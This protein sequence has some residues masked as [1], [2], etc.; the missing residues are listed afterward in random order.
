[1]RH[2]CAE[3]WLFLARQPIREPAAQAQPASHQPTHGFRRPREAKRLDQ[4]VIQRG[5]DQ[6]ARQGAQ[7]PGKLS[8]EHLTGDGTHAPVSFHVLK[9]MLFILSVELLKFVV[10]ARDRM[11][12]HALSH[13]TPE[14]E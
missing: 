10:V 8:S 13:R 5:M 1:M 4:R 12:M 6:A 7:N 2:F 14:I 9:I 3:A 11:D